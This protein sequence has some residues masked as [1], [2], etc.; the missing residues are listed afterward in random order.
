MNAHS[1]TMP[2]RRPESDV[3][4]HVGFV[5]LL[6]LLAWIA[7]CRFWPGIVDLFG[8]NAPREVMSG[9]HA[10]LLSM[11]LVG[12]A[13]A[14]WSVL[15]EKVHRRPS[16]GIDWD[17]VRPLSQIRR[18]SLTKLAGLW[19]TWLL[20]GA[21]YCLGRWYWDGQYLFAMRIIGWAA[22]PIFL[23]SIPYIFWLDRRMVDPRD[24]SWHF[25]ALLLGREAW[26]PEQVKKHWRAWIIKGFFGAFMISI[27]P[28][29]FA[30][31]VEADYGA[32]LSNPVAL[33]THLFELLFVVDVQ[34]G[35]VGYLLTLRP[36]DAHIRSGN[37]FI[38]GWLAALICYPPFVYAFMGNG[39]M[40]QYEYNTAG[41]GYW[42]AGQP[43]LLWGWAAMLVFLTAIY[44]WATVAFGIRFSNL[45]YRGIITNGPYR[46]TRH[47]AYLSKNLFWWLSVLPFLVTSASAVDAIRNTVFLGCVSAVYF[48]RARTEEAHLLAEDARYGQYHAWMQAHGLITAPLARLLAAVR[49]GQPGRAQPAE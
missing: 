12:I 29:G 10:A 15:V 7:F 42:F 39:G 40:I 16:T 23:L 5:G 47:P 2:L 27:L 18:I 41:W 35:T 34:I 49:P 9:P 8:L 11:V 1:R 46:F 25:G 24:H 38:A 32:I 6:V 19:A 4:W 13:M 14:A 44:A 26:D 43:I 3:S 20:I 33:G 48:W 17:N 22:I 21:F 45:T 31:V 28:P 37:P 36:L 30:H